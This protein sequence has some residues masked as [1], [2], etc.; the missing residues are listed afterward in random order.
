MA[1]EDFGS[2]RTYNVEGTTY[3]PTGL[4]TDVHSNQVHTRILHSSAITRLAEIS[5]ICNDATVVYNSVSS[6]TAI[7][8]GK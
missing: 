7:G 6:E 3:A 5:A 2:L 8:V 4:I 1:N